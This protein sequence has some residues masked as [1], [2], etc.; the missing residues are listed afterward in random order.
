MIHDQGTSVHNL[1]TGTV[2]IG[3]GGL[4]VA[5]STTTGQTRTQTAINLAPPASPGTITLY[6]ILG[7]L[8]ALLVM[9]IGGIVAA[10]AGAVPG[11][12]VAGFG[13]WMGYR[14][15]KATGQ[16]LREYPKRLA[17]YEKQ[18][19]CLRCGFSGDQEA[20]GLA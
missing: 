19:C 2:G 10:S 3:P 7:V 15:W 13:V 14:S 16:G 5:Q 4:G 1:T 9:M 8:L 11:L 20:F 12:A 6:R 18:W 17:A